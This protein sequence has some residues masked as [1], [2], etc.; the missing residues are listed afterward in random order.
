[1]KRVFLFFAFIAISLAV[2][3]KECKTLAQIVIDQHPTN[4][5]ECLKFYNDG[6]KKACENWIWSYPCIKALAAVDT[7][8]CADILKGSSANDACEGRPFC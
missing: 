5:S 1:M 2:V 4:Q 8:V 6:T 3:C 7:D